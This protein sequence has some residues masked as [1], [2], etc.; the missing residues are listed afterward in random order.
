[1]IACIDKTPTL[2]GRFSCWIRTLHRPR[3]VFCGVCCGGIGPFPEWM[4][5]DE[6]LE[7]WPSYDCTCKVALPRFEGWTMFRCKWC[8][9]E[10]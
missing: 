10:W 8:N 9:H 1:M 6:H 7:N 2:W 5:K 4:V 3:R